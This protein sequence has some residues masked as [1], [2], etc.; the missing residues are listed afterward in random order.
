[1][2]R[3]NGHEVR[4]M[5]S[6]IREARAENSR[7]VAAA[8]GGHLSR[9]TRQAE[10]APLAQASDVVRDASLTLLKAIHHSD[11]VGQARTAAL[12][13][14][15]TLEA[16]LPQAGQGAKANPHATPSV[17]L[18]PFQKLARRTFPSLLS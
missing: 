3:P 18:T 1:M 16:A 14:V 17:K 6:L 15:D 10:S 12:N 2:A 4:A 5:R 11:D 13:S 8:I 7:M 9:I